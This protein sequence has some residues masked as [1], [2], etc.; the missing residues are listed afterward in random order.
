MQI[1]VIKRLLSAVVVMWAVATIVF[2]AMR[3]IPADPAQVVLGDYASQ[4]LVDAFRQKMGLNLPIWQQYANFLAGLFHGD[5]GRSMVTNQPIA[6]QIF[7]VFPYTLS[8]ALASL[9]VG[10]AIGI[11]LGVVT[12][13][14][15]NTIVDS[16]GRIFALAGFSFP[17]FYLG[18]LLLIIFS[19]QLKWFPVVHSVSEGG[20]ILEHL[21]KLVLPAFS[22][23]LI[24]AAYITRLTRSS[25]LETLSQDYVRTAHAKGLPKS[26]VFYKHALR[27]VLIPVVTA[28]GL[29]TGSI[30]GGAVLTETVF[31]RPGLG[32][33]LVG[34]IAQR[35]YTLIQSGV[36]MFAFVVLSVNLLVDLSYAFFD[37]RVKY[38]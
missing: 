37:P 1:Y 12:A 25:M 32:K 2:F 33:L 6:E 21:H 28:M 38:E 7:S 27:N 3:L 16:M 5:L 15:R 8:L 30:L 20:G 22:L 31:S 14:R 13:I 10:A 23:G 36:L 9:L 29:Y 24:Q 26:V 19:V 11:P 18:I 35:D 17:G 34:A 4:E